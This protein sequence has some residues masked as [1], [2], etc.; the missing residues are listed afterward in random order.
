[1]PSSS[2]E[3]PSSPSPSVR[4]GVLIRS[5]TT[6]SSTSADERIAAARA[7]RERRQK[8]RE[9]GAHHDDNDEY[10]EDAAAP[11]VKVDEASAPSTPTRTTTDGRSDPSLVPKL[12]VQSASDR[13]YTP[14][15]PS[16][17]SQSLHGDSSSIYTSSPL[18]TSTSATRTHDAPPPS[19]STSA[20]P[21]SSTG[22]A[23]PSSRCSSF[24]VAQ[25]PPFRP[26]SASPAPASAPPPPPSSS[27]SPT[28][29]PAPTRTPS[30]GVTMSGGLMARLKAQRAAKATA[31]AKTS[32]VAEPSP[33]Q[34]AAAA[35]AAEA[36]QA[37]TGAKTVHEAASTSAV[38]PAWQSSTGDSSQLTSSDEHVEPSRPSAAIESVS[39]SHAAST[40]LAALGEAQE[41]TQASKAS[42]TIEASEMRDNVSELSMAPRPVSPPKGRRTQVS[43]VLGRNGEEYDFDFTELS[44]VQEQSERSSLSTWR[45]SVRQHRRQ[46]STSTIDYPPSASSSARPI[47]SSNPSRFSY[48]SSTG[49]QQ[50]DGS[51]SSTFDR[52]APLPPSASAKSFSSDPLGHTRSRSEGV[53]SAVNLEKR[54]AATSHILG[55]SGSSRSVFS[56]TSSSSQSSRSSA[57]RSPPLVPGRRSASPT[58]R[59]SPEVARRAAQFEAAGEGRR[60]SPVKADRVPLPLAPQKPS[61]SEGTAH[62][63]STAPPAIVPAP[64]AAPVAEPLA[65]ESPVEP[66]DPLVGIERRRTQRRQALEA[67]KNKVDDLSRPLEGGGERRSLNEARRKEVPRSSLARPNYAHSGTPEAGDSAG[68]ATKAEPSAASDLLR[69]SVRSSSSKSSEPDSPRA[70]PLCEGYLMVPPSYGVSVAESLARPHT[71]TSRYCVLTADSFD[72]RPTDQNPQPR[73]VAFRTAEAVRVE[74]NP[75]LPADSALR[76]FAVILNDGDPLL[77]ACESRVDKVRWVLALQQALDDARRIEEPANQEHGKPLSAYFNPASPSSGAPFRFFAESTRTVTPPGSLFSET[78]GTIR[79]EKDDKIPPYSPPIGLYSYL[80][81]K[82]TFRSYGPGSSASSADSDAS[83]LFGHGDKRPR[84]LFD[85]YARPLRSALQPRPASIAS[86]GS[87]RPLP[88]V[89][90][91]DATALPPLVSPTRSAFSHHQR[92]GSDLSQ[93]NTPSHEP[94]FRPTP[95]RPALPAKKHSDLPFSPSSL[96]PARPSTRSSRASTPSAVPTDELEALQRDLRELMDEAEVEGNRR[97]YRD[98]RYRRVQERLRAFRTKHRDGSLSSKTETFSDEQA[99]L[100][101]KVDYL[102][103]ATTTLLEKQQQAA[104]HANEDHHRRFEVEQEE[105]AAR[106]E[107]R[108]EEMLGDRQVPQQAPASSSSIRTLRAAP[109]G[110]AASLTTRAGVHSASEKVEWQHDLKRYKVLLFPSI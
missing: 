18:S 43:K 78:R 5:F 34:T 25:I 15:I 17:P 57:A 41:G 9:G 36:V 73:V 22:R 53:T 66:E 26:K 97:L 33:A 48:A 35:A 92:S 20:I 90:P 65:H 62:A 8:E 27:S 94:P 102:L 105:L 110:D 24:E 55:R 54:I 45:D 75:A 31:E 85:N 103:Q 59:I 11:L 29:P 10:G 69:S 96:L 16:T 23:S 50:A 42:D 68:E 107:A 47:F 99:S 108:I 39:E 95:T 60:S 13:S 6:T 67:Y 71:W 79:R 30:P 1:M 52:R 74:D 56:G 38:E 4:E 21:A 40:S 93:F 83:S 32:E 84:D 37:A 80:D 49:R 86:S 91:K 46:G 106:L 109:A 82:K 72:F 12:R 19:S 88:Q 81:D 14:S 70:G 28:P 44:D 77:F 104:S 2:S 76:P 3:R 100:A 64:V 87:G 101:E 98:H 61:S 51:F 89:P 63:F 7:A 58:R